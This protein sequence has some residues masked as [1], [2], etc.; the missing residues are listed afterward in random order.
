MSAKCKW[1]WKHRL[2]I[3]SHQMI[4]KEIHTLLESI[5]ESFLKNF[6]LL[7]HVPDL[8]KHIMVK[9]KHTQIIKHKTIGFY[10]YCKIRQ[11]TKVKMTTKLIVMITNYK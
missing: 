1:F 5:V 7:I 2:M 8:K 6:L 11:S 9:K 10:G 3:I 4:C